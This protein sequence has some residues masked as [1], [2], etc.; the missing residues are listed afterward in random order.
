MSADLSL[1]E[2]HSSM[3][4]NWD[5]NV[6]NEW[7]T[8]KEEETI[9]LTSQIF[10]PFIAASDT[11]LSGARMPLNTFSRA[12]GRRIKNQIHPFHLAFLL[13]AACSPTS[14]PLLP[15]PLSSFQ[16][17]QLLTLMT[18]RCRCLVADLKENLFGFFWFRHVAAVF[19]SSFITS[20]CCF[21]LHRG[22]FSWL[23]SPN[24]W[25]I[26]PAA[27]TLVANCDKTWLKSAQSLFVE[28]AAQLKVIWFFF[29]W[30]TRSKKKRTDN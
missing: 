8:D 2:L 17:N 22:H 28:K 25:N 27:F 13:C 20:L 30:E 15:S 4:A 6:G 11:L 21:F 12:A 5:V 19:G 29:Y 14:F 1:N 18:R 3:T 7:K 26:A 9:S 10:R 24:E 23:G 16:F